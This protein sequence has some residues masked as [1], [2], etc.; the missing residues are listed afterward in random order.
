[1]RVTHDAG[2]THDTPTIAVLLASE[3]LI[4]REGLRKL[5]EAEPG[6]VVVGDVSDPQEALTV[7]RA[8]KPHVVIVGFSGRL[9]VRTLRSLRQLVPAGEYGRVIVL[10][11][12]IDKKQMVQ[13]LQLGVGGILLKETS[14]RE[15][16]ESVRKVVAGERIGTSRDLAGSGEPLLRNRVD[17]SG[18]TQQFGLT[19]RELD[20]VAAVRRG[21]SNRAIA[22]R[23]ALSEDTVKHHLTSVFDKTG[24]ASR[25]ELAVFAMQYGLG[26]DGVGAQTFMNQR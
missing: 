18:T 1:M 10:A 25:L 11:P 24:V 7:T 19:S 13:A 9:L 2:E 22:R 6:V 21:D 12:R 16:V 4:V 17:E 14:A 20:I 3:H 8:V 23:L 5:L 15:L 26:D